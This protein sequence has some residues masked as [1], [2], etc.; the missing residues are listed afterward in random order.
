MP[1]YLRFT[2]PPLEVSSVRP[3]LTVLVALGCLACGGAGPGKLAPQSPQETLAQ[4]M[5]AVKA[6]DL[7]RM[8][9]LWGSERGLA[10]GH[11]KSTD[12][13]QRLMVQIDLEDGEARSRV[14][15]LEIDRR[16]PAP[17]RPPNLF[18]PCRLPCR[19]GPAARA[20]QGG[21]PA[22]PGGT[23]ALD[24]VHGRRADRAG[25]HEGG[26]LA[27]GRDGSGEHPQSGGGVQELTP[28]ELKAVA[29]C[30][31]TQ[32]APSRCRPSSSDARTRYAGRR[33]R[34]V[35]PRR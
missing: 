1:S 19:R 33:R 15:P 28:R 29:A 27:G 23:A 14:Q 6:N 2:P 20:E 3:R 11:L 4:F 21:P 25:T 30:S 10:S 31:L 22:P 24:V 26:T 17:R 18:E 5:S 8:R 9:T 32:S 34:A 16:E 12:V 35:A 13:N 7:E